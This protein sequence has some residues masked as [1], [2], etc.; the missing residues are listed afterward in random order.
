MLR[1]LLRQDNMA[2]VLF[3]DSVYYASNQDSSLEHQVW[4]ACFPIR[5]VCACVLM[6]MFTWRT[7]LAH[8]GG[9]SSDL[10]VVSPHTQECFCCLLPRSSFAFRTEKSVMLEERIVP[11]L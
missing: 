6:R 5:Q 11:N 7:T 9:V 2:P 4:H 1:L 10:V 3:M 8:D